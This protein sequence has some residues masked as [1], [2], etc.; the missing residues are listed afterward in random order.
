MGVKGA[1]IQIMPLIWD[2][3]LLPSWTST[4]WLTIWLVLRRVS[5]ETRHP[6]LERLRLK[7]RGVEGGL[8]HGRIPAAVRGPYQGPIPEWAGRG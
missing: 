2:S 4:P 8:G 3:F 6:R 5:G 1:S 7:N